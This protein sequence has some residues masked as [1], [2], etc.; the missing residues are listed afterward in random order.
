[1]RLICSVVLASS[2]N[3]TV[4]KTPSTGV[5]CCFAGCV[6]SAAD[7]SASFSAFFTAF[8]IS[9]SFVPPC[10]YHEINIQQSNQID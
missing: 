4:P 7:A 6:D 8:M 1:M 10:T 3:R 5:A 9:S 2:K